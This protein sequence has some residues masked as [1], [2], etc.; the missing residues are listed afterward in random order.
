MSSNLSRAPAYGASHAPQE[1][2]GSAAPDIAAALARHLADTAA[3]RDKAGVLPATQEGVTVEPDWDAFG[4]RQADSGNVHFSQVLLPHATVTHIPDAYWSGCMKP[5][6]YR[7][8][9][10]SR[11]PGPST[12]VA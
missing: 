8:C 10:S 2:T 1:T 9:R 3:E 4:Q 7:L 5:M 12:R 6:H 11:I